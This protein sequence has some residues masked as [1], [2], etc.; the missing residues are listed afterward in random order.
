MLFLSGL[1]AGSIIAAFANSFHQDVEITW[2]GRHAQILGGGDLLT[3][4]M[5]KT[6]GGAGFTS[7]SDY[8]FGR[9]N[10]QMKLIAG[11]SAGT[12]TTFYLSSEGPSH[13]EID[14]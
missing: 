6:T 1:M 14:L 9:F 11:N 10:M 2:G 7:K 13:D 3:L 4:T 8:L 12:V 5:D